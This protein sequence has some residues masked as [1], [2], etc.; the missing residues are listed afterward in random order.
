MRGNL[1]SAAPQCDI[2]YSVVHVQLSFLLARVAVDLSN[3]CAYASGWFSCAN[4]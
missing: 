3:L 4:G 2:A 1:F